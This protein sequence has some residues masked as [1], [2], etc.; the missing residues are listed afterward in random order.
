MPGRAD[1]PRVVVVTGSGGTG[2]GRAIAL[3][4][5]A[6]GAAVVVSDIDETGGH[7]TV[8]AIERAGGRAAFC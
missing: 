3:R 6:A 5:G 2:C 4:F 7:E 1:D 8:L